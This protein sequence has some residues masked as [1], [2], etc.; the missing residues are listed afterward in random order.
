MVT[1]VIASISATVSFL[2]II[3]NSCST[4]LF[5]HMG[6]AKLTRGC[7]APAEHLSEQSARLEKGH[8]SILSNE[9]LP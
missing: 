2:I 3:S 1:S 8:L 5:G 7:V 9:Y 4:W 6:N